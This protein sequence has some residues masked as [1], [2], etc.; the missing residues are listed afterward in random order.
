VVAAIL[1]LL[2]G[3]WSAM[4]TINAFRPF[5][6][7]LLLFPSM[8]WS[9]L[10]IGLPVQHVVLQLLIAGLLAWWG[11]LDHAVGWVGAVILGVAWCGH[12]FLYLK[13]RKS[14][15]VVDAALADAGVPR[16]G[17][18]VARW[19][20]IVAIPIQGRGIEKI[21]SIPFRRVAGKTLSLDVYRPNTPGEHRP[22]LLYVHGGAWTVGSKREQGLPLLQHMA[23]N[24]WVCF[25]ADYRLSPGAT[26]PDHLI[27]VKSALAWIREHGSEYGADPS[28]VAVS[29]GSAGGHLAALVGLTENDPRYQSGFEAVDTS[30]QSVV[31]IYGVYDATNR[32]GAQTDDYVTLLMEPLVI[33]AFL[34]EEPDK[35][36]EA[37]PID[38]IHPNIP[39]FLVIQGD[40][41][42]LAPVIEAR[43]FVTELRRQ[44]TASVVYIEFPGAQHIFDLFYSYQSAQM[45]EA[46]LS[47]LNDAHSRFAESNTTDQP[48]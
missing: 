4:A 5:R 20:V 32:F 47:F 17:T 38:R 1:L 26:F 48:G 16:S 15:A 31:P 34:G 14:K 13:S 11:A 24:G 37:S 36:R 41:D 25:S 6:Q 39:P 43:A 33:K 29:G 44:S 9:W 27:D 21:S 19:R 35:F 40:N 42:T 3:V 18:P 2:L 12:V 30:V 10:V 22:A 7:K 23:R 46:V 45:V 28:F 8:T